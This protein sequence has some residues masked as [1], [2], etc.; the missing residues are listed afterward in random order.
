MAVEDVRR[1]AC[2]VDIKTEGFKPLADADSFLLVRV[3]HGNQYRALLLHL[4]ARADQALEQ[5]FAER[6]GHAEYLTGRLHF[7]PKLG[8]EV[9]QLLEREHRHLDSVVVAFRMQAG[10]AAHVAQ[11][12]TEHAAGCQIDHRHTMLLADCM[13]SRVSHR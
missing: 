5:R 4:E 7:R 11:L 1:A 8:I 6:G 13:T 12:F 9:A 10:A 2:C 3:A